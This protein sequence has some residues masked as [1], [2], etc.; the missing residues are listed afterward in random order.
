VMYLS[1]NNTYLESATPKMLLFHQLQAVQDF[2]A[3]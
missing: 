2:Q 3:E 1:L